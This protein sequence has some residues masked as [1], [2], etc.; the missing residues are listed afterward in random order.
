VDGYTCLAYGEGGQCVE[1]QSGNIPVQGSDGDYLGDVTW[2]IAWT[3]PIGTENGEIIHA[4]GDSDT[5]EILTEDRFF[6]AF[7]GPNDY[8]CDF[9]GT[10]PCFIVEI[11]SLAKIGDP[12]RAAS[13]DN[14]SSA[15]VVEPTSV[16]EP[17]TLALLG[18]CLSGYALNRRRR[19]GAVTN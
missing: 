17:G 16:P 4:P 3:P 10:T 11:D 2:L 8:N 5:F 1:Y 19:R 9:P 12:V 13:S 7:L 18:V 15:V 6:N 14:F